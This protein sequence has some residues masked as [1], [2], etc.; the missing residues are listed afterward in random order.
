MAAF[1]T[2]ASTIQLPGSLETSLTLVLKPAGQA[3]DL[4]VEEDR[5]LIYNTVLCFKN[6]RLSFPRFPLWTYLSS[7]VAKELACT[8]DRISS[9]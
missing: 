1:P 6:T 4:W 8:R 7:S 3:L 9:L 5:V 2:C